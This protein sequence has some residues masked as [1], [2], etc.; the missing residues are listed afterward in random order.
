MDLTLVN[1]KQILFVL[2][3]PPATLIP[4]DLFSDG[5]QIPQNLLL[6]L[7][8]SLI[9]ASE[10]IR[11]QWNPVVLYLFSSSVFKEKVFNK[12]ISPKENYIN[13]RSSEVIE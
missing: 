6:F 11:K 12:T 2:V 3:P 10:A 5:I 7:L 13:F 1:K 8:R 4:P 9:P